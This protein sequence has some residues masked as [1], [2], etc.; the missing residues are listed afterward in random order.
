MSNSFETRLISEPARRRAVSEKVRA[1]QNQYRGITLIPAKSWVLLSERQRVDYRHHREQLVAWM[2]NIGKDPDGAEGYAETTTRNRADNLD[3]IYRWVW[4]REDGYTT[5]VTHDHTDKY[6]QEL[7]YSDHSNSHKTNH[8]KTLKTY[9]RW[10]V[11][12]HGA[13]EWE[14]SMSF[15]QRD[16]SAQ[17]RDYLTREERRRIREAALEYGSV[18]HYCAI[19]PEDRREW[20]RLLARRYEKPM[21]EVDRGDFERA[22]GFKI[23][24]LVW[25][26]LDAGLRPVE[27]GR[28]RPSWVDTDNAVLRIP[29]KDA[30]KSDEHWTVSIQS[31]TAEM[32]SRWLDERTLYDRYDESDRLWLT[33]EENPY[34]SSSLKYVLSKLCEIA[35]IPTENRQMTWYAIRHSVG[36]YMAREEGLAAAQSQLR[37]RSKLTTM[38]YDQAPPEDRRNALNRMG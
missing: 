3:Q 38:K 10:R 11:Q 30:A 15:A 8:V 9:W 35:N 14:P 19:T 31:R 2:A 26:G 27:V 7:A 16:P 33:R 21:S 6:V 20:K 13:D 5:H 34:G 29:A 17:P 4:D 23:P 36:T 25:T 12:Q 37:H 18:P 24:S 1:E 32:L 22:N 28:A